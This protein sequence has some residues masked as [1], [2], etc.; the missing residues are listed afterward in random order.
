[1]YEKILVPL[2][3]SE[4]AEVALPYA[5]ELAGR[6][7]SDVTLLSVLI[8]NSLPGDW[9]YQH[10]HRIYLEKMADDVKKGVEKKLGEPAAQKIKVKTVTLVG[11]PAEEIVDY[12]DK[13]KIDLIVMSTHGLTGIKRWSIGSVA[14]NV[15]KAATPPVLLIRAKGVRSDMRERDILDKILVPLD[16]FEKSEAVIPYVVELASRL[17]LEVTLLQTLTPDYGI[18]SEIQLKNLESIRESSVNYVQSMAAYFEQK[19]IATKAV[20]RELKL[21]PAGVTAEIIKLADEIQADLVAM[22][23]QG[24]PEVGEISGEWIANL[25]SVAEKIVHSGNTPLLLVKP[26]KK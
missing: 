16:G 12:T 23:S 9:P 10:L 15:V 14:Y 24:R 11:D 3:G 6:L 4:P 17:K 26:A 18:T 2:D 19:G 1:M 25:G 21:E 22:S 20:F 7:G 5:E 13:E 8:S